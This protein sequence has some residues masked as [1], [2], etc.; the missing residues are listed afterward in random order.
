MTQI[1]GILGIKCLCVQAN[2][3]LARGFATDLDLEEGLEDM[4]KEEHEDGIHYPYGR[5]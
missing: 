3:E 5:G 1:C 2:E 4:G